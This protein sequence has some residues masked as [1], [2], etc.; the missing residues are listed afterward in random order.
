MEEAPSEGVEAESDGLPKVDRDAAERYL[1]RHRRSSASLL[2]AFR[3]TGDTNYLFEAA[4]NFSE[5]PQVQ[6]TVL[7]HNLFPD[8]RRKW[9]EAFKASSPSNSLASYLSA[10]DYFEA[11]KKEAAVTE[12]QAA[13]GRSQFENFET[14]AR[15]DSEELFLSSGRSLRDASQ[16]ALA[17]I[18]ADYLPELASFKRLSQSIAGLEPQYASPEQASSLAS[19]VQ[20]GL[21]LADQLRSGDSGKYIINGLVGN[22]DEAILLR[23]LDPNTSYSFLGGQTPAQRLDELKQIK[24]E[25]RQVTRTF[26][27]IYPTLSE[28]EQLD[29]LQRSNIYGEFEAERWL[30]QEYGSAAQAQ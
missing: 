16:S 20:S 28:P 19:V 27:S 2:A 4:R 11:G 15:L 14:S 8:D 25:I 6:W 24:Q 18:A 23:Q 30:V 17:V 5:D 3:G 21:S 10:Q 22:A 1:A 29:Y 26:T 7:M 12:L 9:L 13:L